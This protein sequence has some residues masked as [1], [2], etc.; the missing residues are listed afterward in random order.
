[1]L[2]HWL[3]QL[4]VSGHFP[5]PWVLRDR[6]GLDAGTP[7]R[8]TLFCC[9]HTPLVEIA[10]RAFIQLGFP[11]PAVV[12]DSG[13]MARAMHFR[14]PGVTQHL[15]AIPADAA[16]ML[17]MRTILRQ[18]GGVVCLAD[19]QI[20]G[21]LSPSAMKLAGRTGARVV[22]SWAERRPGGLIELF[23]VP[24]P[25]PDCASQ[26]EIEAN[27]RWLQ[28]HRQWLFAALGLAEPPIHTFAEL[29]GLPHQEL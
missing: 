16:G 11:P 26:A 28:A 10:L 9:T 4:T 14:P 2:D 21:Q 8:G 13:N 27:L 7:G 6:S 12:A 5:I 20:G 15:A 19:D 18:G 1:M 25:Y 24:A 22:F 17:R 3:R 29:A 23:I